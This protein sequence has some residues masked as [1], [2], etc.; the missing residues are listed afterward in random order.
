M[1]C[2][3][4]AALAQSSGVPRL[5]G[6]RVLG[7]TGGAASVTDEMRDAQRFAASSRIGGET[8]DR[9]DGAA[10]SVALPVFSSLGIVCSFCAPVRWILVGL[11]GI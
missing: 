1:A 5:H 2:R 4:F 11:D 7:V 8:R 3:E 9:D 10:V 6:D